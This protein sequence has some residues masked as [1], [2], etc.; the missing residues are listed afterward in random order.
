MLVLADGLERVVL[1]AAAKIAA[2]LGLQRRRFFGGASRGAGVD[3][4]VRSL[5]HGLL[6]AAGLGVE[7]RLLHPR[8]ATDAV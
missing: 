6:R 8:R 3:Q 1:K 7:E 5:A 4:R 2:E